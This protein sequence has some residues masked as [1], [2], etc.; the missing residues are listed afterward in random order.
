MYASDA[1]FKEL[2]LPYGYCSDDVYI[3]LKD[4]RLCLSNGTTIP[5]PQFAPDL[6]LDSF[7]EQAEKEGKVPKA[8]GNTSGLPGDSTG[9]TLG[10]NDEI[11]ITIRKTLGSRTPVI[12][13]GLFSSAD[14]ITSVIESFIFNF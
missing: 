12:F 4:K 14:E 11:T 2:V 5:N 9:I 1:S 13:P 7:F 8:I 10:P 3:S 6:S